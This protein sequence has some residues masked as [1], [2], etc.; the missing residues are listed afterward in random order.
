MR[1]SAAD[2][3]KLTDRFDFPASVG[4]V[5]HINNTV[6][7]FILKVKSNERGSIGEHYYGLHQDYA[8]FIR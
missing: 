5:E 3:T 6:V 8:F 4:Q 7:P 1:F 2:R